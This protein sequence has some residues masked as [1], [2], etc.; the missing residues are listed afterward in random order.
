[1]KTKPPR[2]SPTSTPS[3]HASPLTRGHWLALGLTAAAS[4]ALQVLAPHGEG[5]HWWDAIPGVYAVGAFAGGTLL[6]LGAKG[7]GKHL[8][9]RPQGYYDA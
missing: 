7:L 6:V 4:V 3:T 1:M 2:K 5:G 9:Q 8:L